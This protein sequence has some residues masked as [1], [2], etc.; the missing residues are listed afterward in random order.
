[1]KN[2]NPLLNK[3]L[4]LESGDVSQ[5]EVYSNPHHLRRD[6]HAF[7]QYV[8]ERKVKR[9]YRSNQL[10]KP[11]A[12]RLAKLMSHPECLQQIQEDG[13][14]WWIDEVDSLVRNL[15]FVHYDTEGVYMGYSSHSPSFPDNY[16]EFDAQRYEAFLQSSLLAQ[17]TTLFK[18][19]VNDK[20][21]NEFYSRHLQSRLDRFSTWGSA[22]GVMSSLDLPK[23]RRFLFRLLSKLESGTW[24]TTKALIRYLK[25]KHPYFLIPEASKMPMERSY[26]N[27]PAS[28]MKRYGNFQ[29][30]K[31]GREYYDD[32]DP[33][34]DDAVDGFER[35]EGRFLERFLEGIPLTLGYVDVAYNPKPYR[36][37][38]PERGMV[39]AFRVNGRFLQFMSGEELAPKVTVLPNFEI[40]VE[41]PFYD[42]GLMR[43]LLRFAELVTEDKVTVLRLD[44]QR[45]K[46]ALAADA[47][48]DPVPYLRRL[49]GRPLPQNIAIELEEWV[50]QAGVFTLYEGFALLEGDKRLP[51][52]GP[53]VVE[54]ITPKLR[55]IRQP[56]KAFHALQ[57][58]ERIPLTIKHGAGRWTPLPTKA[59]TIFPKAAKEKPKRKT[60]TR[61]VVGRETRLILYAPTT[62]FYEDL[63][64]EL[65]KQRCIFEPDQAH[66]AIAYAQAYKPQV[67]AALKALRQRYTIKFED[68]TA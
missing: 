21:Y 13:Y 5:L 60:K 22:T 42:P 59:R 25:K 23:T 55:L 27:R 9:A 49:T 12:K 37:K 16:I 6:I 62:A 20:E 48:L 53:F 63:R 24:Y 68:R 39:Q 45:V 34:P 57:Q 51:E 30:Y 31:K 40:H 65:F 64:A 4:T 28:R 46:A 67:D 43:Q 7:V 2:D 33:I 26:W 41:S 44:K 17:E 47:S 1:M 10:P 8:S 19:M 32:E 3:K 14:S 50:G 11:D 58:A 18:T 66:L 54:K 61:V 56:E 52:I 15:G 38:R 35:V 29:E 36:G